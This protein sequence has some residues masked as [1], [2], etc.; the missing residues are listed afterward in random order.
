MAHTGTGLPS[1][2]GGQ[3]MVAKELT[4]GTYQV[5]T[6]GYPHVSVGLVPTP[7]MIE[8]KGIKAGSRVKR[9]DFRTVWAKGGAGT[10]ELELDRS[11]M[12]KL[13]AACLGAAATGTPVGGTTSKLHTITEGE[14]TDDSLTVQAGVP[15]ID[16]VI[17][18]FTFLGSVV[19]DWEISCAVGEYVKMSLGIWSQ[20][21]RHTDDLAAVSYTVGAPYAFHQTDVKLGGTILP[22]IRS[23]SVKGTNPLS[24]ERWLAD[25]TGLPAK[26]LE[27]GLRSYQLSLE[28]E[29]TDIT[30]TWDPILTDAANAFVIECIGAATGDATV[31]YGFVITAS[32]CRLIGEPPQLSGEETLTQQL[33]YDVVAA[34]TPV[35]FEYTNMDATP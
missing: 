22:G 4:Y 16:G 26:P 3:L 8:P 28:V 18:P 20:V 21:A 1:G 19:T 35:K 17:E 31:K 7:E 23:W 30:K 27:S 10:V 11:G 12:G 24:T 13:L 33:T 9:S 29:W 6:I 5:P 15:R 34:A 14:L 25:G 2:L 32:D